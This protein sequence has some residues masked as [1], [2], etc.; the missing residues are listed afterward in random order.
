ML[1]RLGLATSALIAAAIIEPREAR[2]E[3][4]KFGVGDGHNGAKTV[5]G[6]ETINSYAS[7][8]ADVAAGAST[9]AIGTVIGHNA[10]FAAND[11]VL[12]WRATGVA[13]SEAT[14]G[15]QSK[16][17]DLAKSLATTSSAAN[18]AGLVG[19]YELARVQS[20]AGAA[21]NQTLTLTKPLVNAYT[22]H[23]SQ[24]VRVPEYT[25]VN[26][27][28]GAS[29]VATAWQEVGGT[30]S[31]PKPNNPWAGGI[32]IFMATGAITNNGAIHANGRGFHGG[33]P[34]ARAIGTLGI[35]CNN[36][37]LDGNPL[38]SSF[39]PKGEGVVQSR[40]VRDLG[41][42]GNISMAGG[43]GNCLEGGGGGGANRG[44]GGSGS[45]S[46]L[47]LGAGGLGGVGIDYDINER[48]TMG[49]GGGAGRHIVGLFSQVSFGGFGGGI[50][51]IRGGSMSGNGKLE[52][53]GGNGENSGLIGLP[54]GVASEGSGGGG[55]GGTVVVRLTGTLDCDSIGSPGGDGGNA[56]VLGLGIFGSGGG[57]GG[58]RVLYQAASKAANC[59]IIVTPGNPGNNGGGGSQPGGAG[60]TQPPPTGGF[61]FDPA[62]GSPNPCADP[63]PVCDT[64]TGE[65]KKCSGP[66]GGGS[67][68]AC[69]VSVE[70]VCMT[71]G[72]C[73]ACNGDFSS[74]TTQACQLAGSPYCFT[75]GGAAVVGSCGKCTANADC[76]GAGHPG[77][78]CNVVAGNCGKTCTKDSDCATTEWCAPQ[79]ADGTS[80]CT[81][82]T[83][84]GQ[85]L[86][87]GP[88]IHGD[89]TKEKGARVCLSAVCDEGDDLCGLK[90]RSPCGGAT[91]CRSDIC[92]DKDDLCGLP[93][94]EPCN[95]DGQCR[96]EQ[97]K[98][99]TCQGC[100][101]DKDCNAGQV[102]DA[103][104]KNCVPGCRPDGTSNAD[105][106]D[107]R[108]ACPPGE[109]CVVA[110]GGDI[111]QCQ[112][113]ADAGPGNDGGTGADA[114]DTAGLIEGGGCTCNT[115]LSSAAS[116]F[117]I[118]GAA[119]SGL[120]LARRRRNRNAG[121]S[122]ADDAAQPHPSKS[123]DR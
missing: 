9:I 121:S 106:G 51:Y 101:D 1:V 60:T 123:E 90:N 2:A 5:V 116:P 11:L 44:N 29:L 99:G 62:P 30:P 71:D 68:L 67:S 98:D 13:A 46:L 113:A 10:G 78:I 74:G 3:I 4:D 42:K 53:N 26:V 61:C 57:G 56:Q 27:P 120:L 92:F 54:T 111:G 75:T 6:T 49:G 117:A 72:S 48:L 93:N 104:T 89:C 23:V 80:V 87:P 69:K 35:L 119:L 45:G 38:N 20:V 82:K 109:Q 58:G 12:V 31:D 112:P 21:G 103:T 97:C 86:P 7:I 105:G 40:Y 39:A 47:G 66:F 85:P 79:A 94:G 63:T 28:A 118:V 65:C 18:Q 22:R 77:P 100:N 33:L 17:L 15:N 55:A 37:K 91:E 19:Q 115:T 36:D 110:D 84:N 96:S 34:V 81:P 76:A 114:G 70:P 25:T 83:P 8:R 122:R 64:V 73:Q 41:G 95:G 24:V 14:S 108:G 50:V 52:A 102:C 32:L 16:R 107:A 43:G 88:P 59:D